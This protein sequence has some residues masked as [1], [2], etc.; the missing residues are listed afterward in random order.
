MSGVVPEA[1][2][3]SGEDRGEGRAP[4]KKTYLQVAA[5]A[6]LFAPGDE[7]GGGNTQDHIWSSKIAHSAG[8]TCK[9]EG[10]T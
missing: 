6:E 3:K 4:R 7:R 1:P 9:E 2:D 5:P 10:L 8:V